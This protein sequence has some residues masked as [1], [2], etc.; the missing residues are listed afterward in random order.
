MKTTKK[1]LSIFATTF[2]VVEYFAL[3]AYS[4]KEVDSKMDIVELSNVE[5]LSQAEVDYGNVWFSNLR[6][7][8]C[9]ISRYEGKNG[10]TYVIKGNKRSCVREFTTNTCEIAW[11]TACTKT[12]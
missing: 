10:E 7:V 8:E 2:L 1:I 11:E 12:K 4:S 9:E 5:A 6:Y 3:Q